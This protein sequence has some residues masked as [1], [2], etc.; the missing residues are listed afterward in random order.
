MQITSSRPAARVGIYLVVAAILATLFSWRGLFANEVIL[1]E[2]EV[3]PDK[4][5]AKCPVT[6]E[7]RARIMADDFG[8]I[9]YR[10]IRSDEEQMPVETLSL[11]EK[12]RKRMGYVTMTW[13]VSPLNSPG[14][15]EYSAD[16]DVLSPDSWGSKGP[17]K[18]WVVCVGT[19]SD[20]SSAGGDDLFELGGTENEDTLVI[21]QSDGTGSPR[22]P[23]P[24]PKSAVRPIEFACPVREV[25]VRVTGR[26]PQGWQKEHNRNTASA[27]LA[28]RT[29]SGTGNDKRLICLYQNGKWLLPLW[30]PVPAGYANCEVRGDYFRCTG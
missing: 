1:I 20:R 17:A 10:W 29:V 2:A 27:A 6:L 23:E 4:I 19:V 16:V 22:D 11:P 5:E 30:R 26:L 12:K 14:G 9:K 18:A 24:Q 8:D 21:G 15:R 7:F 3:K 13:E 25:G 28:G